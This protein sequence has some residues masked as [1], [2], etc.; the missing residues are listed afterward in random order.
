MVSS[1]TDIS[2]HW[3]FYITLRHRKLS[4]RT[5]ISPFDLATHGGRASVAMVLML[6]NLNIPASQGLL[7]P[8]TDVI[9]DS[10][11]PCKP[12]VLPE[13]FVERVT[14][15]MHHAACVR[16]YMVPLY[17]MRILSCVILGKFQAW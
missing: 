1:F 13:L 2:L 15:L 5:T 8:G 6:F 10:T 12:R 14:P 11:L 16:P 3:L 9:A 17:E 4:K 7:Q